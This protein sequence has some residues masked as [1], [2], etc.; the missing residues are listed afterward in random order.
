MGWRVSKTVVNGGEGLKEYAGRQG[1]REGQGSPINR[2]AAVVALVAVCI[3][4]VALV[5]LKPWFGTKVYVFAVVGDSQGRSEVWEIVMDGVNSDRPDFLLHCGDMVASGT[6]AQYDDFLEGAEKLKMPLHVVP[7]NHDVRGEGRTCFAE[8]FRDPPYYSFEHKGARFIGLDTSEGSIDSVQMEWLRGEL[9]EDGPK[10]IFMHIPLYD[11]RP[12]GDHCFLDQEQAAELEELFGASRVLAVFSGHVHMFSNAE[13][14]GVEYV[15][16]GGAGALLYAPEDEGGFYHYALVKVDG[17]QVEIETR[18][19]D[20]EF[21]E[22]SLTLSGPEGKKELSL[23]QLAL[24]ETVEVEVAFE[25]RF[26]NLGGHGIYVGVPVISLVEMVG[27]LAPGQTLVVTCDDGYS[28]DYAYENVYPSDQWAQTQGPMILA[29]EKDGATSPEW[30]ES[31]RLI[32]A[33]PDGV[34][35]NDDC[36]STSVP[37]QGWNLYESAGARWARSVTRIE[38]KD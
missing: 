27:G 14:D 1:K 23:G 37:G 26:G 19:V 29:Y 30:Q 18:R 11:P 38:V 16:T 4:A 36:A 15:T 9:A 24:M 22:A 10:F 5:V 25:N 17:E 12:G 20:V 28:Q 13:L 2:R 33:P 3:I 7:G 6:R 21:E 35:S 8:L 31:P 34:Y 32:M